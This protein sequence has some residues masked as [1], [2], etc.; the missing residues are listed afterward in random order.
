MDKG[1]V[2]TKSMIERAF[3]DGKTVFLPRI[4]PLGEPGLKQYANQSSELKMIQMKSVEEI[5]SLIPRGKYKLKEP[6]DGPDCKFVK[7]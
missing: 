6:D 3:K 2:S 1:E 5:A 7:L 4:V